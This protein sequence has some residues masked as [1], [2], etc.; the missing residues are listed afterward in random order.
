M[1]SNNF[2]RSKAV[3]YSGGWEQIGS[4]DEGAGVEGLGDERYTLVNFCQLF[5]LSSPSHYCPSED[6]PDNTFK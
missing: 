4:R 5:L 3:M 2:K 1:G 6:K